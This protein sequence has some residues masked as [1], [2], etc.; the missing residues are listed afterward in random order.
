[1]TIQRFFGDAIT[2][3]TDASVHVRLEAT[4]TVSYNKKMRLDGWFDEAVPELVCAFCKPL[5]ARV[6]LFG[7]EFCH[8]LQ[9]KEQSSVW[10]QDEQVILFDSFLMGRRK[11][12]TE[13]IVRASEATQIM[14]LDCEIR[15]IDLMKKHRLG[16]DFK[17]MIQRANAYIYFYTV[18]LQTG[19]WFLTAPHDIREIVDVMPQ[20]FLNIEKYRN[21]SKTIFELYDRFCFKVRQET[22]Y[23]S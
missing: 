4:T 6:N 2:T 21:I 22:E 16:F 17:R 13:A 11:R 10:I 12:V 20:R 14:E 9:W 1:M 8:F 15:N 5:E 23:Y 3:L 18:A 7:H 19:S